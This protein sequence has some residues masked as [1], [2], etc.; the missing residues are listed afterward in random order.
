MRNIRFSNSASEHSVDLKFGRA[1]G[2][3]AW[4][5]FKKLDSVAI[6]PRLLTAVASWRATDHYWARPG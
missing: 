5:R 6:T 3:A 2:P 4:R 1:Q